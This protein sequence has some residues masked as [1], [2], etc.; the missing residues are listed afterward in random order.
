MKA[1]LAKLA[2]ILLFVTAF[3]LPAVRPGRQQAPMRGYECALMTVEDLG[4]TVMHP[5]SLFMPGD[6]SGAEFN[7]CT[8][9]SG[10]ISPLVILSFVV[11][12]PRLRR[13][14]AI[15]VLVLMLAPWALFA[16]PEEGTGRIVPLIGHYLWMIG[17]IVIFTP[18]FVALYRNY[19][20]VQQRAS[21]IAPHSPD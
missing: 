3:F 4:E 18:E 6:A 1:N 19:R 17:G 8:A 10:I 11:F 7:L 16:M 9:L 13:A 15:T 20:P 12:P 14:I 21:A 5:L 2:G